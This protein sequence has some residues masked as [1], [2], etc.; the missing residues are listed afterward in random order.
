[1]PNRIFGI[2]AVDFLMQDLPKLIDRM[3][4]VKTV[5]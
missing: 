5:K 2:Y 1:M 3:V 4:K